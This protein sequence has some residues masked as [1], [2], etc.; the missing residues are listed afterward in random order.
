MPENF[1]ISSISSSVSFF[2]LSIKSLA[3]INLLLDFFSFT[4]LYEK[5]LLKAKA[6]FPGIVHGVVVQ[7]KIFVFSIFLIFRF[8]LSIGNKT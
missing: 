4:K 2:N 5:F 3:T 6:L 7:I 8:V 1:S